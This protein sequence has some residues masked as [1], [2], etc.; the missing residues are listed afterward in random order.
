MA[1][2]VPNRLDLGYDRKTDAFSLG[3]TAISFG[4]AST[5]ENRNRPVNSRLMLP[6]PLAVSGRSAGFLPVPAT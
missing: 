6:L 5:R 4:F 3:E 2:T 1:N